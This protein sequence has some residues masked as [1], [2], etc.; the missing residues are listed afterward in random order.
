MM[1]IINFMLA[2]PPDLVWGDGKPASCYPV[3]RCRRAAVAATDG[4]LRPKSTIVPTWRPAAVSRFFSLWRTN[5]R[6]WCPLTGQLPV[7]ATIG[8]NQNSLNFISGAE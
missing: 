5:I 8:R 2:G 4:H 6:G 1:A 7:Q 3:V